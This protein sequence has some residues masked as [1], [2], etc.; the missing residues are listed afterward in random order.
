[1]TLRKT[2]RHYS[3]TT[4]YAGPGDLSVALSV[5]VAEHHIDRFADRPALPHTIVPLGT[6]VHLFIRESKEADGDL[7]APPYLYAG[8]ATYVR[9]TK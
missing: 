9:H 2:E 6:T 1:M 3:P 8:P 7:G 5:G 4:M